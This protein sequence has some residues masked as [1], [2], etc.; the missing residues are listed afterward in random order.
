MATG[1]DGVSI[2]IDLGGERFLLKHID[3]LEELGRPFVIT[4][5]VVT[6]LGQLD[7]LQ[8]LGKTAAISFLE[9]DDI[10]RRFHGVL[11][12]AEFQRESR[13]GYNYR[14]TLRPFTYFLDQNRAFAIF[15][16]LSALAIVKKVFENAGV[17]DVDYSKLSRSYPARTYCVQYAE[18]DFAFVSRLMEE[19]GIYYFF[20]FEA[21][22]HVMVLCDGPSSHSSGSPA[23]LVFNPN[24]VSIQLSD[25][26]TQG[27]EA[28]V[29][30]LIEHVQTQAQAK[31]VTRDFDLAK[32]QRPVQA[33]TS[34]TGAHPGDSVEILHYPGGF[35]E[36][37]RGVALTT[38]MLRA[39]RHN[40][41][42]Y[43]GET[44]SSGV[45]CGTLVSI[46]DHPV[47]RFNV[48]YLMLR[49][50]RSITTQLP[51]AYD[52]H[53]E[54]R[55]N[56]QF[57]AIP[58]TVGFASPQITP[59]PHV[60]GLE[61]A[62]VTGPEGETIYTDQYGRVKVRFPWDRSDSAGESSTCWIRVAQFGN[63]G[64]LIL[65]R[66]GQ[67]VMVDFVRGDPDRPVV[68]GWTFNQAAMPTYELPANKT[69]AVWR[70]K[71]Y[72]EAGSYPNA[73]ALDTGEPGVNELRFEDK[74][75]AEEVFLH[76]E[77][78]MNTRV[79]FAETHHVG[80]NQ[81]LMVGYDRTDDV[82]NDETTT[83]GRH[84]TLT[85]G[86]KQTET[87]GD[88]RTVTVQ[89]SDALTVSQ[90]ITVDAGTSI[91]VTAGSSITLK[92]G[93]SSVTIDNSGVTV[94][95]MQVSIEGEMGATLKSAMTNVQGEATTTIT[96]G[97]VNIN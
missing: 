24:R 1:T 5:E 39:R 84:Q 89:A 76:A 93:M 91:T 52:E 20:R 63:L 87:I 9:F 11:T 69:R 43:R 6:R 74:G 28:F 78:D 36:E 86:K 17:Q 12:E 71:R 53:Q 15:Q 57:D 34:D 8:H 48:S 47:E 65:P 37:D 54:E 97:M 26:A 13:F 72:G 35:T 85:I 82:G 90:S 21:D 68:C 27:Q 58:A 2:T 22:K 46:S 56:A 80:Q 41:Q 66:V 25:R 55:F 75:G 59:R 45:S 92:V 16:D 61:T 10:E 81:A 96:G 4:A 60:H 50:H 79:R 62:I 19:E 70:T 94:K 83:I 33:S 18:S 49:V 42:I 44:P 95:G 73:K 64:S 32:P 88:N 38:T 3:C 29:T 40:R 14:L 7:L 77:R 30:Q 31:V 67:E 23:E 51:E